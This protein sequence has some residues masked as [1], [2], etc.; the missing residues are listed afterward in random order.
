MKNKKFAMMALVTVL[1]MS[2]VMVTGLAQGPAKVTVALDPNWRNALEPLITEFNNSS[3]TA[4]IE[5][6]WGGDQAKLLVQET[7]TLKHK[8]IYWQI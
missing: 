7:Y 4:Q 2:T 3:K 1:G 6:L 5:V 8:R